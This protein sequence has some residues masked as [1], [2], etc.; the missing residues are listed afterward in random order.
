[1]TYAETIEYLVGLEAV[2]G[3]DLKLERVRDALFRLG[4]PERAQPSILIG[5]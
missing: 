2:R 5:N 3:W 4:S 1:V